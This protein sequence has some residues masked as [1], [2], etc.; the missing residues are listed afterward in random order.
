MDMVVKSVVNKSGLKV[1]VIQNI[2]RKLPLEDIAKAKGISMDEL[3]T[4][5][6][7]IVFSGT[8]VNIDYYLNSDLLRALIINFHSFLKISNTT[9]LS[10]K[11]INNTL[12][13]I[14]FFLYHG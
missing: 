8:S 5:L 10:L 4:E 1:F 2:D 14:E 7:S 6:E 3:I 9:L 11:K 12:I 13:N